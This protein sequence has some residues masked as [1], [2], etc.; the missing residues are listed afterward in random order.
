M[1]VRIG[2]VRKAANFALPGIPSPGFENSSQPKTTRRAKL[3]NPFLQTSPSHHKSK[4]TGRK[5]PWRAAKTSK[6][7]TA[8][9]SSPQQNYNRSKP[10]R[11]RKKWPRPY[12]NARSRLHRS[13]LLRLLSRARLRLLKTSQLKGRKCQARL[14]LLPFSKSSHHLRLKIFLDFD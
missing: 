3:L 5:C 11:R 14:R 13:K 2:Q 7:H 12:K 9:S 6:R 8:K 4:I 1:A 10:L